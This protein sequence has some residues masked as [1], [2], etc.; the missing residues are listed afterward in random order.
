MDSGE[1]K[2]DLLF[3][4]G[5]LFVTPYYGVVVPLGIEIAHSADQ[6]REQ[7]GYRWPNFTIIAPAPWGLVAP[8]DRMK[9]LEADRQIF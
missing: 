6:A 2:R 5:A 4:M 9:A 3:V 8:R 7:G 1:G